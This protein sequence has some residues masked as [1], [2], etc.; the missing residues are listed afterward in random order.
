MPD[1]PAVPEKKV[2]FRSDD[3]SCKHKCWKYTPLLP[4]FTRVSVMDLDPARSDLRLS[5]FEDE[6]VATAGI[7]L[8]CWRRSALRFACGALITILTLRLLGAIGAAR[9]PAEPA[10]TILSLSSPEVEA[11]RMTGIV[12]SCNLTCSKAVPAIESYQKLLVS[13][14]IPSTIPPPTAVGSPEDLASLLTTGAVPP[15]VEALI[16]DAVAQV[17]QDAIAQGTDLQAAVDELANASTAVHTLVTAQ[18][19]ATATITAYQACSENCI[20]Q[21]GSSTPNCSQALSVLA[22]NS[23]SGASAVAVSQ[24]TIETTLETCAVSSTGKES[25]AT[26]DLDELYK[27]YQTVYRIA[28]LPFAL[29]TVLLTVMAARGWNDLKRSRKMMLVG[30]GVHI[31][32]PIVLGLVP[33]YH[34]MGFPA[35]LEAAAAESSFNAAASLGLRYRFRIA[36]NSG[37]IDLAAIALTILPALLKAAQIWKTLVPESSVWYFAVRVTPVLSLVVN[38]TVFALPMQLL[39][40]GWLWGYCIVTSLQLLPFSFAAPTLLPGK[41]APTDSSHGKKALGRAK[42]SYYVLMTLAYVCLVIFVINLLR[43]VRRAVE[44]AAAAVGVTPEPDLA[45]LITGLIDIDALIIA[46]LD[47]FTF[48]YLGIMVWVDVLTAFILHLHRVDGMYAKGGAPEGQAQGD[49]MYEGLYSIAAIEAVSATSTR[50]SEE[51][52]PSQ[53]K[54]N[55]A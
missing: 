53:I 17:E 13:S 19:A 47:Y 27:R 48:Y 52:E 10:G 3:P 25:S 43:L 40:D 41:D 11:A 50:A 2:V 20:A 29:I 22:A 49:G 46:I 44:R 23:V 18:L 8:A 6:P 15:E 30:Y 51:T 26:D 9:A 1:K 24:S 21:F 39:G 54:T 16:Y 45:A 34:A 55:V 12:A 28:R 38:L 5:E 37:L 31:A 14:S 7:N 33:W 35:A 32:S 4:S 36:L 42:C